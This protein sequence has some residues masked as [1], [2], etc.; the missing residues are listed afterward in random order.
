MC[1]FGWPVCVCMHSLYGCKCVYG[2]MHLCVCIF[3]AV[4]VFIVGSVNTHGCVGAVFSVLL[5]V[6]TAK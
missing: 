6:A 5:S 4:C 3:V 1:V 2:C